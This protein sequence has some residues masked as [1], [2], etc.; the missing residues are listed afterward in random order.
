MS[1][2]AARALGPLSDRSPRH[3]VGTVKVLA[4]TGMT[5]SGSTILDTLLGEVPGFFSTGELHYLWERGLLEGRA[6]GCGATV[7]SCRVWSRVLA[8]TARVV[9]DVDP[10]DVVT[11]QR[12]AVRARHTWRLL[13]RTSA[14]GDGWPALTRYA[15]VI[16][17]VYRAIA[18]VTGSSV[19]VDS[20]K[21]A[22]DAA[23]LG[24]LPG[25]EPY[26][27]HLVRDPRAVAYSW[28]RAK[29]E[30]D[31]GKRAEMPRHAVARS[32]STWLTLNL[33]AEAVR[34]GHP[35]ERSVLVRYE[36]FVEWPT[37]TLARIVDLVGEPRARLPVDGGATATLGVNHTVSGNPSR[38]RTG[39][40]ELRVDDEWKTRQAPVDR[41]LVTAM[42]LPLLA[43][44]G[45]WIS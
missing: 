42:T 15:R 31:R 2:S 22:S 32:A 24:L 34:R 44:Y 8:E 37:T 40:V 17:S 36:D 13:Y 35:V 6:C 18:K 14:D 23:I 11:W 25:V 29:A 38:F 7:R 43:R 4:I 9:G 10:H 20:S 12:D 30:L 33:A 19:V 28:R 21:R 1:S 16:A 26:F 27:V 41:A 45:Y 39:A 5:R 3:S